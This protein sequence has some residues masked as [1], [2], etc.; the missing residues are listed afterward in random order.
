MSF[1]ASAGA[2]P[3]EVGRG[4]RHKE[5]EGPAPVPFDKRNRIFRDEVGGVSVAFYRL[6][7]EPEIRHA[8]AVHVLEIM[9]IPSE[10]PEE[11]IES[12]LAWLTFMIVSGMPL[13]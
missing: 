5:E 8:D 10:K 7:A 4:V 13:P 1:A 11:M 9:V 3:G 2:L 6:V 12:L